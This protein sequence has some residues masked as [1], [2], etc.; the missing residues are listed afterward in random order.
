MSANTYF[1]PAICRGLLLFFLQLIISLSLPAQIPKQ[2]YVT[3]GDVK[4]IAKKDNTLY[5]GGSF[6]HVGPNIPFGT[7]VNITT[8]VPDMS[9]AAPNYIVETTVPDGAG[10]WYIGGYF[11]KVGNF[12]RYGIARI[13]ASGAVTA[14]NA[15]LNTVAY[16]RS[17]VVSGSRVYIGGGFT[18]AGGVTR[19]NFAALDATTGALISGFA[20]AFNGG[21]VFAIAPSGTNLYVGGYFRNV[22]GNTSYP[23]LAAINATTG[24]LVTGFAPSPD[25]LVEDLAASGS[26][27]Y[28]S[29]SF[30]NIGGLA[31]G[32]FA[33][34][35]ATSGALITAFNPP[36][37]LGIL[38]IELAG[39]TLYVA[40]FDGISAVNATTGSN[41]PGFSATL[42]G[43]VFDVLAS[44]SNIYISGAFD[45][46]AGLR[47][48]YM[49]QLSA[50]GA[51]AA[52]N[53]K[54][55]G[56]VR[57]IGIG[58]NNN[59]YIGGEFSTVGAAQRKNLAAID[60]TTGILI[61]GTNLD[62]DSQ[63]NALLVSGSTLYAGGEFTT[64]GGAGH[65]YL[66]AINTATNTVNAG[67]TASAD[68]QVLALAF[69]GSTLYAGG[70]FTTMGGLTRPSLAA[71]NGT[72]GSVIS[73][74]NA[75]V[76]DGVTSFTFSSVQALAIS[77]S[78]LYLGGLGIN[79]VGGSTRNNLAAVNT[80]TG[81]LVTG[82][83]ANVA[84]GN[85]AALAVS[86]ST[87]YVGGYFQNINGSGGANVAALNLATGTPTAFGLSANDAV[88]ALLLSG[89]TLYVGGYF[90]TIGGTSQRGL[91]AVDATTGT[92][93][94]TFTTDAQGVLSLLLAGNVLYAGG[95]FYSV[96]SNPRRGIVALNAL[97]G[98]VALPVKLRSFTA[99]NAGARNRIDWA[100]AMETGNNTFEVERSFNGSGFTALGTLSGKGSDSKY[101]FYDD[102]P[103]IGGNYYRLKMTDESGTEAYSSIVVVRNSSTGGRI[104]IAPV[105]STAEI[106]ITNTD[107]TLNG[108]TAVIYSMEGTLMANFILQQR[109]TIDIRSWP[110]GIYILR[111]PEGGVVRLVKE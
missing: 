40:G 74:F 63:V 43:I 1:R 25:R 14:F 87:L 96:N 68:E 27:I 70:N 103:F 4:A 57:S 3:D 48:P 49:A 60:A 50:T 2:P 30:N 13:D 82:F 89:S 94:S 61:A 53:P 100:T 91:G 29:G 92:L 88:N 18:S 5:I 12:T 58:T 54:P 83:T 41:V 20:P 99:A 110:S 90:S 102:A 93:N 31:K 44:G 19:T 101:S 22:N 23:Y 6:T 24:A 76:D 73:G 72:T 69:A 55:Q 77:G 10:G 65:K 104:G 32:K 46:V 33:A 111:L 56:I 34:V 75:Q 107:E 16:V 42:N 86:A 105:P 71:V 39:S 98:G 8:G 67:F 11:T 36:T 15:N 97:N 21:P 26:T 84:S 51:V 106:T 66:A 38:D 85:V 52:L 81:A 80:T 62:A 37:Y 95:S 79:G 78:T 45:T 7:S 64:V 9:F 28:V 109:Q 35:D 47:R 59:I 108:Q 17:I